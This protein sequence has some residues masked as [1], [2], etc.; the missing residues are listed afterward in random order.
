VIRLLLAHFLP[1]DR[2]GKFDVALIEAYN[3]IYLI[4]NTV[5]AAWT[6]A[7]AGL[8][9]QL[10]ILVLFVPSFAAMTV[11]ATLTGLFLVAWIESHL[12]S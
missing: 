9:K 4:R 11:F 5:Y 3:H 8:A 1:F 12:S 6:F 2:R 10:E 7:I